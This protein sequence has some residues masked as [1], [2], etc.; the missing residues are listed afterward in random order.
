MET[1]MNEH[2]QALGTLGGLANTTKQRKARRQ[3]MAKARWAKAYALARG[4]KKG[5]GWSVIGDERQ[6]KT[7]GTFGKAKPMP[8]LS[9]NRNRKGE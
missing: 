8:R 7:T 1:N 2:A 5:I 4:S 3:N 9:T 6:H